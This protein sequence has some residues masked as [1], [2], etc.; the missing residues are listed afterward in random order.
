MGVD[1]LLEF[2]QLCLDDKPKIDNI[3]WAENSR[4]A[5]FSFS[6]MYAWDESYKQAVAYL[7]NRV[8]VWPR[9][10]REPFFVFPVGSGELKRC[11]DEIGMFSQQNG[12]PF[13]IRGIT[14]DNVEKLEALY[15]DKFHITGDRDYYDYIY[16]AEK[17]ATLSG[18]KLQAKRNH[19]NRFVMENDWSF[20]PITKE[21]INECLSMLSEWMRNST[22]ILG[23]GTGLDEEYTAIRRAFESYSSLDLKGGLLRSEGKVIAFA[24]GEKISTDTFIIHFE[25]A[26]SYIQ[27][28]YAMINRE[29]ARHI[30]D[31]HPEIKYI[32][33]EDDMGIESLR[34]AK[35]SY[36]PEFL[37]EKFTAV[38]K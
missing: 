28:A 31:T 37:I 23:T 18:K 22:D 35:L 21:V 19:I 24:L 33:R 13:K 17:L 5:D 6:N 32:N 3:M 36:R 26:Y 4:S 34:T 1:F 38:I 29:F 30:I 9:Y 2:K 25:K 7:D 15:P 10:A 8:I 20:E 27:G 16:L 14:C 11:I 12:L